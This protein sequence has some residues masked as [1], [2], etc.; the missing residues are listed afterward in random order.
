MDFTY[1]LIKEKLLVQIHWWLRWWSFPFAA[2]LKFVPKAGTI[3]DFGCGFGILSWLLRKR[4]HRIWAL[5]ISSDKRRVAKRLLKYYKNI[6]I[7][8]ELPEAK[9]D[10]IAILDVLYLMPEGEKVK[11]LKLLIRQL[12]PRGKLLISY[13]PKE[14]SWSYYLAWL[15]EWLMVKVLKVTKGKDINF[16][17]EAWLK[18]QLLRVGFKRVRCQKLSRTLFFW[19]KHVLFV[20]YK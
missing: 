8:K 17:T 12:K 10:A 2:A 18:Q 11:L 6:L 20:S 9:V 19:H 16:E 15:Q 13:V 7:V 3:I 14:R 1:Q 4:G 5:D